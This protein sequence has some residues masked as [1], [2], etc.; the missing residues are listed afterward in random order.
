MEAQGVHVKYGHDPLA[1]VLGFGNV[2]YT[3]YTRTSDGQAYAKIEAL[4][5]GLQ[6]V[7]QAQNRPQLP[8][9]PAK[10]AF[11]EGILHL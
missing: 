6:R 3:M 8:A 4:W 2:S 9:H 5:G 7:H 1:G 11:P 10:K